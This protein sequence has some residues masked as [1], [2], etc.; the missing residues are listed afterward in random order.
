[1]LGGRFVIGRWP[2]ALG[3]SLAAH[4]AIVGAALAAW[5]APPPAAEPT[6]SVVVLDDEPPNVTIEAEITQ[7]ES[8][9]ATA[10]GGAKDDASHDDASGTAEALPSEIVD[11]A[12]EA[13]VAAP[14]PRKRP[15]H[16]VASAEHPAKSKQRAKAAHPEEAPDTKRKKKLA[17]RRNPHTEA[18]AVA[19]HPKAA[20]PRATTTEPPPAPPPDLQ[21]IAAA[22]PAPNAPPPKEKDKEDAK[23]GKEEHAAAGSGAGTTTTFK[24]A[25]TTATGGA[26]SVAD[27]Q[28]I[29]DHDA[30]APKN[31]R[32]AT[33]T[34]RSSGNARGSGD[35]LPVPEGHAND[36]K[37]PLAH[38]AV[39]APSPESSA[40]DRTTAGRIEGAGPAAGPKPNPRRLFMLG[41]LSDAQIAARPPA[42][43]P[44][45]TLVVPRKRA[46]AARLALVVA[47]Q[48]PPK[49][50]SAP[51]PSPTAQDL[52][53]Q[54]LPSVT[55]A[56][57]AVAAEDGFWAG[58]GEAT[59]GTG[60]DAA[61]SPDPVA[62]ENVHRTIFKKDG[63]GWT[64]VTTLEDAVELSDHA[65]V[66]VRQTELGTWFTPVDDLV[67][68][69]WRPPL[70]QL[71]LGVG[72][73]VTVEFTVRRNGRVAE[74]SLVDANVPLTLQEAALAAVP[75]A[76]APPP[77]GYAPLRVRYVFRYGTSGGK[78]N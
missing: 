55:P 3:G 49:A 62:G 74:V 23:K 33:T 5:P 68:L 69:G 20:E 45:I 4:A 16:D 37:G 18:A 65:A 35:A 1:M 71:V 42:D 58:E 51:P 6:T 34:E 32:V 41:E 22:L 57:E 43:Q 78:L 2:L 28:Y 13:S 26:E 75:E 64:E 70:D 67:R 14:H 12:A 61:D 8:G 52:L 59:A 46:P 73:R 36:A 66:S 9:V 77:N 76:V 25:R 47:P 60:T 48:E 17:K 38:T 63:A 27:A 10:D 30:A 29:G 53:T 40:G 11:E 15:K 50:P 19:A 21:A 39:A 54:P 31:T 44:Q 7:A 24:F 56:P 72:G